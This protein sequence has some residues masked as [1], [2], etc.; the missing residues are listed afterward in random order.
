MDMQRYFAQLVG[1][2][3]TR[4][5]MVQ[6]EYDDEPFPTYWVKA[7]NGDRLKL[8]FSRDEEG[9]GPGFIF[10]EEVDAVYK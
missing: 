1:A 6:R 9:N 4:F 3:I 8:A 2:K 5:E 10:I 7:R